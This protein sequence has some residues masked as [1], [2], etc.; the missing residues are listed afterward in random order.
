MGSSFDQRL[1]NYVN[2]QLNGYQGIFPPTN[3]PALMT[4][5]N[6]PGTGFTTLH[7]SLTKLWQERVVASPGWPEYYYPLVDTQSLTLLRCV[8]SKW[9]LAEILADFWHTHFSVQGSKYEVAPV[10]VHYDRDVIRPNMLGN[11][12]QMLEAVTKSTAMMRYLDNA[13]NTKWGPNEN[14]ARELQELHTL[15]AR[16]SYDFAEEADIPNAV[17][18]PG[19]SA[20]LPAGLKAGYSEHDVRQA[21]LALTGWNISTEWSDKQNTGEYIYHSNWHD[22]S[23]K[24]FL[25]I[26]ISVNGEAEVEQILDRLAIHPNTARYVCSKLCKRLI[27]DEP[28]ESIVEAA[29]AVF[30]DKW[31]APGQLKQVV[32]AIIL[33]DEFKDP[34][35]WGAKSKK[36]FELIA[37]TLR[38]CGGVAGKLVR[39]YPSSAPNHLESGK[40]YAFS[41]TLTWMLSDT[42]NQLF[43]WVTP[44]G[45]PDSKSAWL[46]S[47]PLVM[48][49]R[50]INSVF[51]SGYRNPG[52]EWEGFPPVDT[53][54]I[55]SSTFTVNERNARNLV[56][57][58]IKRILGYDSADPSSP[59]LDTATIDK[60]ITFM[61][62]DA[63]SPDTPLDLS[64]V[65]NDWNN[66]TWEAYVAI[67]L[68]TLV[69]SIAMLP[70]NLKR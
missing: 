24:R 68:Q 63:T 7:D 10:F 37:G 43:N 3:D 2:A 15:G 41:R 26:N 39:P 6:K 53:V 69:A 46:G 50:T 47:T 56:H 1:E 66:T 38:S 12:R 33:S 61:Q 45:F 25:G 32:K 48:A 5:L 60:L 28:P 16:H 44:D 22:D 52:G 13:S 64:A 8:Y 21:A 20:I 14:F 17:S 11:F 59:Q 18:M 49:W 54:T 29:A 34:A 40:D 23:D 30:N 9:Q 51:M 57:Y 67:R 27:G 31:Q 65:G 58:W 62:Q 4:E 19:S 35:N 36:P 70:D 42:G 55:S